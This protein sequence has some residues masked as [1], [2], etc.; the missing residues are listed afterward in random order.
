M[1]KPLRYL[2]KEDNEFLWEKEVHG[3]C[4]EDVKQV[5]MQSLVLKFFDPRKKTVLPCDA[6]VSGV[7]ACH[8]QDGHRLAYASRALTPGETNYAQ[9]EKD[10]LSI[11]FGVE[12]FESY[13]YGR[14]VFV[15]T[16]H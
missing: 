11:N 13:V 1:A 5:L 9:I 3:K 16:D 8:L 2:V 4:L 10:L 12:W 7:G 14:K 15:D 6:S